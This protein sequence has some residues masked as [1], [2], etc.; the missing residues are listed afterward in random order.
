VLF[1]AVSTCLDAIRFRYAGKSH[2]LRFANAEP[3][4]DATYKIPEKQKIL[5]IPKRTLKMIGTAERSVSISM[6]ELL[7]GNGESSRHAAITNT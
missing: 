2:A 3:S 7:K 1:N 5:P 4:T 6:M